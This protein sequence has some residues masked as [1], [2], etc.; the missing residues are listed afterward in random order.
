MFHWTNTKIRETSP[1]ECSFWPS[2]NFCTEKIL[3]SVVTLAHDALD[4][5]ENSETV[6]FYTGENYRTSR[7]LRRAITG[8]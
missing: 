7:K 2:R 4:A 6:L 8:V 3:S 1:T 5:R